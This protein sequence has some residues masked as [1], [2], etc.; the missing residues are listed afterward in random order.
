MTSLQKRNRK[1]PE[2]ARKKA[3]LI[4][5]GRIYMPDEVRSG[6]EPSVSTA[7]PGAGEDSV[8][9]QFGKNER[10]TIARLK[11]TDDRKC[12]FSL[13]KTGT[14]YS[15]LKKGRAYIRGA[16]LV[17]KIIHSPTHAFINLDSRCSYSCRFCVSPKLKSKPKSEMKI[18]EMVSQACA[19]GANAVAFT[20]GVVN[21]AHGSASK[22]IKIVGKIR[23]EFP[24]IAIGV[25]PYLQNEKD[26]RKLK[27]AG[28]D[29][30]KLNIQ[31]CD[32]G[33]FRKVCPDLDYEAIIRN[34]EAAVRIFGRGR[35][36]SNII[37]GLGETD[38][39][40]VTG[41]ER[42][43]KMG[44]L[45]TIRPLSTNDLNLPALV[46]ALGCD[47]KP[48][49]PE[50]LLALADRQER[51][52]NKYGLRPET[53]KTMCHACGCCDIMPFVDL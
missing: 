43:A 28:A 36:S 27:D 25:E 30:I 5:S 33:I 16:E 34:I 45:A 29:E 11:L 51:I 31:S 48:V 1:F 52:F 21:G 17:P 2:N 18:I 37:I 6:Y 15:V 50:R 19:K 12:L 9:L 35:V 40:V 42:L 22:M 32:R 49:E 38:H 4:A 3:S 13:V 46:R 53:M 41:V 8:F 10:K 39:N 24:G 26:V 44:A 47:I 7:G 20:S 23:A 14:G